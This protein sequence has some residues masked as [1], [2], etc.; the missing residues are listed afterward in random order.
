MAKNEPSDDDIVNF[1]GGRWNLRSSVLVLELEEP[2]P[3]NV[4][5]EKEEE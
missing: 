3:D 2:E 1:L 4:V 5:E